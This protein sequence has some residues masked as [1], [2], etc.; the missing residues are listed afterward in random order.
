MGRR[1]RRVAVAASLT[2]GLVAANAAAG[3]RAGQAGSPW[4]G[5][6]VLGSPAEVRSYWTRARMMRARPLTG[7]VP[8]AGRRSS[9]QPSEGPA[10]YVPPAAP[11]EPGGAVRRGS[12]LTE[13]LTS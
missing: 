5:K 8:A 4:A 9:G 3:D 7:A 2:A 6:A 11:G 12:P 1:S 10:A 13:A